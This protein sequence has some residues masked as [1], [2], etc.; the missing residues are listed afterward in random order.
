MCGPLDF[1]DIPDECFL[2]TSET[3]SLYEM[4]SVCDSLGMHICSMEELMYVKDIRGGG[5]TSS[6]CTPTAAEEDVNAKICNCKKSMPLC[7]CR[8]KGSSDFFFDFQTKNPTS[9]TNPTTSKPTEEKTLK[10]SKEP[11]TQKPTKIPTPKPTKEPTTQKPS[12]HP[13][14]QKPTT[15]KPTKEPTTQK[16]TKIP[17]PKPTKEPTTL[18]PTRNPTTKKP[19]TLKPSNSPTNPTTRKPTTPKPILHNFLGT[20]TQ[21]PLWITNFWNQQQVLFG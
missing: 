3:G 6:V 2:H 17:T 19:S 5:W 7:L 12:K 10:P 11:T 9:P 13:T 18:K 16:P 4:I 14:T 21:L 1:Y 15:Q 20:P 8:K